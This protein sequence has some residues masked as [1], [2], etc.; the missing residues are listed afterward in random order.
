[1]FLLYNSQESR[2]DHLPVIYH[3]AHSDWLQSLAELGVFGT[4]L[5]GLAILL[6]VVSVRRLRVS[7]IA[8]FLFTGCL[9]IGAYA[10]VEFPFGNVAV[11]LAWWLCFFCAI[12]YMRLS[13]PS[14]PDSHD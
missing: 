11:V 2:H 10:W 13:G 4:A 7:Q 8:F 5:I 9:L 3:D 14:G 6:P 12:Q 1:V